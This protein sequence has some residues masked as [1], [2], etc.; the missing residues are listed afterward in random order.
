MRKEAKGKVIGVLGGMGPWATLELFKRLLKIT[1]AQTDQDH[2]QIIIYSNPKIPDRTAAL[3]HGGESPL[4]LL[5]STARNLEK[6]GADF[7]IMPC[8]T[9]HYYLDE[10]RDAVTIPMLN[11]IEETVALIEER[12]AGLLATDG[13]IR[14]GLYQKACQK[15]GIK[16]LYP[17]DIGQKAV[18][19]VVYSVKEGRV[20]LGVKRRAIEVAEGLIAQGAETIIAGCTEISLVLR[21]GDISVPLFDS[22]DIL[23]ERA[24][25]L[26]RS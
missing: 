9:A 2:L 16:L 20:D 21:E 24:I 23:A 13:T 5:L 15:R 11:M 22:L 3:L 12:R 10:L 8:N 14:S 1:P 6:A 17:D 19:D 7:I 25:K 26:A 18:M 4:P